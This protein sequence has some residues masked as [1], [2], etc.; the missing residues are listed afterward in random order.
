M[1]GEQRRGQH[2]SHSVRYLSV[3]LR[4]Y[5]D[6]SIEFEGQSS[7]YRTDED[8]DYEYTLTID[9]GSVEL[10]GA[11]LGLQKGDDVYFAI[12]RRPEEIVRCGESA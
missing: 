10:M 2:L 9:A 8:D 6:G 11:A 12:V 7:N 5:V 1:S 4:E 3:Y